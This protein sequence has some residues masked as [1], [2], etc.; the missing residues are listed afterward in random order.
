[1][2][3]SPLVDYTRISP[4]KTSPR[5]HNIDTITIHCTAVQVT[6]ERLGE[7]FASPSKEASSNYGIAKNGL[8]GMYVEERDRSWCSSNRANDN[9]AITIEVSSESKAPYAVNDVAYAALLD[10]VTDICRR[11]RIAKLVWSDTKADRVNHVNGCNMTV[12][13]DYANKAC[14]G[15]YLY[16]RMGAIAEEVN[17]RLT[18]KPEKSETEAAIE[19]ITSTGIMLGTADGDLHLDAPLTRRQYAVMEYRKHLLDEAKR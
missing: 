1:M 11:N 4:N 9:R 18:P 13:R 15:D 7:I 14:P 6:V 3:N 2:S 10:L 5:N 19:W 12:H 8:I 17:R 16:S